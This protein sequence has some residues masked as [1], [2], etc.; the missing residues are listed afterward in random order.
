MF[1]TTLK[2]LLDL[3]FDNQKCIEKKLLSCIKRLVIKHL[4]KKLTQSKYPTWST[5]KVEDRIVEVHADMLGVQSIN[6]KVQTI[7]FI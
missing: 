2:I 3:I 5:S 1:D 7:A 4:R 6:T